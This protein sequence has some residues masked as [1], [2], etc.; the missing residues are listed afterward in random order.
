MPTARVCLEKLGLTGVSK[1]LE[2]MRTEYAGR[3]LECVDRNPFVQFDLWFG[4]AVKCKVFEPNGMTLATTTKKHHPS[5]RMVLLKCVDRKGFVFFTS[6]E[7]RKAEQIEQCDRVALNFWWRE[8]YRQVSIEGRIEKVSR[9]ISTAYFAKRPRG[10]QLAAHATNLAGYRKVQKQYVGKKVPCPKNWGGYRVAA[11]RFEFWQGKKNR[12]HD[13]F[14]YVK[15]DGIWIL[16]R[17]PQ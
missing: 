7:S 4:E 2:K 8:L 12:L 11:D 13:R 10:A 9:A 16:S 15:K 6:Y 3:A 14:C 1:S 17:L 5:S